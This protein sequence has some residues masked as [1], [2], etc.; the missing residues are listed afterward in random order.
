VEPEALI[1]LLGVM[2]GN[3]YRQEQKVVHSFTAED[4]DGW[5]WISRESNPPVAHISV[6]VTQQEDRLPPDP[7]RWM[8]GLPRLLTGVVDLQR[9]ARHATL[10][11]VDRIPL[12]DPA[13]ARL[14][15][16]SI[17]TSARWLDRQLDIEMS[18]G[19]DAFRDLAFTLYREGISPAPLPELLHDDLT[20]LGD[21][22]WGDTV[23]TPMEL[24]MFHPLV[25]SLGS[26][27]NRGPI[28]VLAHAGHGMNSYGLN[29]L[30]A[31][32][33]FGA[34][35]Q[36]SYGGVYTDPLS[37]RQE[38]AKV[39][40][41]LWLILREASKSPGP[42]RHLLVYSSFRRRCELRDLEH[43]ES[44]IQARDVHALFRAYVDP[45]P[46]LKSKWR[47]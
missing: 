46:T 7:D 4:Q 45:Y 24:Y 18:K 11:V 28:F 40:S 32:G 20:K 29:L 42:V 6:L 17:K 22:W 13:A 16:E 8:T 14:R 12:V 26:V 41:R 10:R 43:P 25:D 9:S 33:S 44:S 35:V 2:P 3:V 27:W 30:V 47:W 1:E 15:L 37:S 21:W 39:F 36:V 34:A 38:I 23:I 31:D 5:L 19:A